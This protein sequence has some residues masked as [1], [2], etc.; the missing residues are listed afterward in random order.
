MQRLNLNCCIFIYIM[1]A[2]RNS[3]NIALIIS[4]G[5]N[6]TW[7]HDNKTYTT[8]RYSPCCFPAANGA[9]F[10]YVWLS[11]EVFCLA[12]VITGVRGNVILLSRPSNCKWGEG[13][14]SKG[15]SATCIYSCSM[16]SP[17]ERRRPDRE[18]RR[19]HHENVGLRC[20]ER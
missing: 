3:I 10:W 7:S 11:Y 17:R 2:F 16:K 8:F 19:S 13:Q 9:W 20:F 15:G 1:S 12:Q 14:V 18:S 6:E 4:C 5:H